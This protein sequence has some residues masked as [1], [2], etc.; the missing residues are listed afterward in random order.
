MF[1]AD[2]VI[3]YPSVILIIRNLYKVTASFSTKKIVYKKATDKIVDSNSD[4]YYNLST[5]DY[6][7]LL[8]LVLVLINPTIVLIDHGHFQYN[9]IS[10]GL[11]QLA[12]Y[13]LLNTSANQRNQSSIKLKWLICASAL[14]CMA[15]NYKQ[16]ELY[17]ALP[18]FFYLLGLSLFKS[19][20]WTQG[21]VLLIKIHSN[22]AF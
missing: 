1:I 2:L 16:M 7:S 14:F 5:T 21:S 19:E 12:V 3:F 20:S 18:F 22:N 4:A 15:L 17:H 6:D 11:T 8:T 13:F 10:L 9:C